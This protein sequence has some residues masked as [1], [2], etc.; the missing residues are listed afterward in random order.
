MSVK[1]L[2]AGL[3]VT[4]FGFAA[5]AENGFVYVI[6]GFTTNVT[7]FT[8]VGTVKKAAINSDGSFG[9]FRACAPAITA[10]GNLKAIAYN[11]YMY[12]GP[13]STDAATTL[14]SEFL[15]GR[16]QPNGDIPAW[17]SIAAPAALQSYQM[18]VHR[19][20]MYFAG[21]TDGTTPVTATYRA[22]I[23]N[24]GSLGAWTYVA[25]LAVS[26]VSS[27][28]SVVV[29]G[30]YLAMVVDA[31]IYSTR[32]L[33]DGSF[34]P[35]VATPM[36]QTRD[37][38]AVAFVK[39]RLYLVG[40]WDLSSYSAAISSVAMNSQ[41]VPAG[42]IVDVDNISGPRENF[43]MPQ[44]GN[45]F[46]VLGGHKVDGGAAA[47]IQADSGSV[48]KLSAIVGAFADNDPL[49]GS[50]G[51]SAFVAGA[52]GSSFLFDYK[53]EIHAFAATET[54]TGMT[55]G[56]TATISSDANGGS[57][58]TL[59]LASVVGNFANNEVV[60]GSRVYLA[61]KT[62]S[63]NFTVGDVV[64]GAT[65][66]AHG[67]IAVDTDGGTTGVLRLTGVVGVFVDGEA[68]TDAHTGAALANG[69]QYNGTAVANGT[70]YKTLSYDG[71]IHAFT[72]DE[73]VGGVGAAADAQYF[74]L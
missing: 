44:A 21:G 16:I 43:A 73:V 72:V 46:W 47:T 3:P 42:P 20:Y 31:Y 36:G 51:G 4:D 50:L 28:A 7:P 49:V 41:L 13:G 17:T 22:L 24:D 11:G 74:E 6:A 55:S 19:G 66:A 30:D 64:T 69:T 37:G 67:T 27:T 53:T 29:D 65:S 61:Y 63:A 62:Q 14:S 39:N 33:G 1:T 35:W 60:K 59:T 54:L 68:L 57:T 12:V 8:P 71:Q 32:I 9:A 52:L 23:N 2:A 18:W 56:A 45:R 15:V 38:A 58:G 40:G 26:N 5:L 70:Q 25:D 10:R 34:M 48:L